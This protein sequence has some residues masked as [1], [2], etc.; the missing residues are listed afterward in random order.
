[1]RS[2]RR[3]VRVGTAPT[4]RLRARALAGGFAVASQPPLRKLCFLRRIFVAWVSRPLRVVRFRSGFSEG[5][6]THAER[7][8]RLRLVAHEENS[9]KF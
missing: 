1:M 3:G 6:L 7:D 4:P 2:L 8:T 5:R 9:K